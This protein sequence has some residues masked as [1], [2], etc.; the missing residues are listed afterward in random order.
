MENKDPLLCHW[1]DQMADKIIAEK[2]ERESYTCASGITPSGTVHLGNFREIITVDLVVRALRDRGKKVRFIYS[3][4]DYDVFRKVPAN[5][6]DPE[7]LEKY[8]RYPITMVPDTTGRDENYA[9]HHEVD[10]ET[11]LPRVGIAPE[12]LYQAS[13]YRANR[14]AEGMKKNT[15]MLIICLMRNYWLLK[16]GWE[17]L[18]KV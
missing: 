17:M 2:G 9:R 5:M 4:D 6:P 3:W 11:Q 14:Y 7:T 13:R 18:V 1:A 12:F 15:L 10:I 8:L 16:K